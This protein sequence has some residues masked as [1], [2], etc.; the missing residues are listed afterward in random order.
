[1]KKYGIKCK[2]EDFVSNTTTAWEITHPKDDKLSLDID[3]FK[4]NLDAARDARGR[5]ELWAKLDHA[6]TQAMVLHRRGKIKF[7]FKKIYHHAPD[8]DWEEE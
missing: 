7:K 4:T 3:E 5:V 1:M 8:G 6:L 2:H